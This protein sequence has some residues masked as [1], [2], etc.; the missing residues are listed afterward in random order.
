MAYIH[1][2]SV[3]IEHSVVIERPVSQVFGFL[4]DFP[5][6]PAWQAEFSEMTPLSDGPPG[7]GSRY[8]YA[9]RLP[10]GTQRGTVELTVG[11]LLDG[12]FALG[13][14]RTA[15]PAA[16]AAAPAAPA[17]VETIAAADGPP[18]SLPAV[19]PAVEEALNYPEYTG[20]VGAKPADA[21][22]ASAA[23]LEA[24]ADAR[25]SDRSLEALG[26]LHARDRGCRFRA[27]A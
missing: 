8:R 7:A 15:N 6:V 10:V 5:S 27:A 24:V 11:L 3:A 14:S 1:T 17:A 13:T 20:N 23:I 18:V 16:R 22:A 2:M 25:R 9:R 19:S 4:S 12:G 26:R 21:K